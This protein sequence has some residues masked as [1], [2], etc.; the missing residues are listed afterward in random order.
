VTALFSIG[1]VLRIIRQESNMTLNQASQTISVRKISDYEM[2][3][4]TPS[5]QN[6]RD[7]A[8]GYNV[9]ILMIILASSDSK[10]AEKWPKE[11][12][13]WMEWGVLCNMLYRR[14]RA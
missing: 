11:V 6:L 5:L 1:E 14:R 2:G 4:Y 3:R 10:E 8:D 12:Q 9:S 13:Q 7:F